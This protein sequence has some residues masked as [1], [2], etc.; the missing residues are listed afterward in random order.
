MRSDTPGRGPCVGTYVVPHALASVIN[1]PSLALH[2]S[3][4]HLLN[5]SCGGRKPVCRPGGCAGA[6]I[7]SGVQTCEIKAV[8]VHRMS[9]R[10]PGLAWV[11]TVQIDGAQI[12]I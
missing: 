4:Q 2:P 7:G 10:R 8:N 6:F 11:G 9:L 5:S 3:T 1:V 12:C